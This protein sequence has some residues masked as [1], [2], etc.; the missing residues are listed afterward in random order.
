MKINSLA[1]STSS[2]ENTTD[3]SKKQVQ[4]STI[5]EQQQE[6]HQEQK[7]LELEEK[8]TKGLS[9]EEAEHIVNGI[10][11]FLQ[12]KYTN[13]SFKL[14][15]KLDKFYVEVVDQETKKVIREIPDRELLDVYAKMT[16]FLGLFID[17]KL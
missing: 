1:S 10:N 5:I 15:D 13:L 6:I 14:H 7:K 11:E 2:I 9:K 17:K 8:R 3:Y 12:P 4:E 16:E